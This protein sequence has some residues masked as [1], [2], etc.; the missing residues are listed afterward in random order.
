M[1]SDTVKKMRTVNTYMARQ[2]R[3]HGMRPLRHGDAGAGGGVG[4]GEGISDEDWGLSE[5]EGL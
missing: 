1:A 2:Q 5:E 4:V 3:G